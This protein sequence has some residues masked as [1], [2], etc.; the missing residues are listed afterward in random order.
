MK[1]S[2]EHEPGKS[3]RQAF[4]LRAV[5][6]YVPIKISNSPGRSQQKHFYDLSK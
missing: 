1:K 4:S 2:V 3:F 6:M 5:G